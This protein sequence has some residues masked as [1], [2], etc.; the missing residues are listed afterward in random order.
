MAL[1]PNTT[2]NRS[3]RHCGPGR[4]L[5]GPEGPAFSAHY[6]MQLL[7]ITGYFQAR[8]AQAGTASG[9]TWGG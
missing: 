8:V 4:G 6:A 7:F 5:E 9:P 3:H 2:S 1:V